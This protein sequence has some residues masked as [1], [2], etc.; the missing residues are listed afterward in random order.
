MK[1]CS[2][3]FARVNRRRKDAPN[4]ANG[5]PLSIPSLTSVTGKDATHAIADYAR[6]SSICVGAPSSTISMSWLVPS[7][8]RLSFR[9]LLDYLTGALVLV[10]GAKWGSQ[11]PPEEDRLAGWLTPSPQ[12][13]PE[14]A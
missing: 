6:I 8:F 13:V 11:T 10:C 12:E 9:P 1:P 2:S 4:C 3:N 5:S 14:Q 7:H